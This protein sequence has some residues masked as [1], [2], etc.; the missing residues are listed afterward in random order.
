MTH[1]TTQFSRRQTLIRLGGV[2]AGLAAW[3]TPATLLAQSS[4]KVVK[5]ILPVSAGSGVDG[6]ARAA[7]GHRQHHANHAQ[8]HRDEQ[9]PQVVQRQRVDFFRRTQQPQQ[10]A[11][12]RQQLGC[13]R[14]AR[15]QSQRRRRQ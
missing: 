12:G 10:R 15:W 2:A 5:F 4:D 6:I 8:R 13:Q 3:G 7:Q 11:A 9:H 1:P 14:V